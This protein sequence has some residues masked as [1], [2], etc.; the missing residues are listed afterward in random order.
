ME[1]PSLFGP[2]GNLAVIRKSQQDCPAVAEPV[3]SQKQTP[4]VPIRRPKKTSPTQRSLAKLRAEG[5][6]CAITEH[7]NP[8]AKLRQDLFGFIDILAMRGHFIM[9]V[10]TTSGGHVSDRGDKIRYLQTAQLWLESPMRLIVV[11]GWRKVG[12]RGMVK[13]WECREVNITNP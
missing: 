9:A 2:S 13:R 7:W 3:E 5:W 1:E 4:D 11:H 10:Q 8:F 12:E 6:T